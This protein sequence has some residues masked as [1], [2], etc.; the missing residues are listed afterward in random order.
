[1]RKLLFQGPNLVA[2]ALQV[3]HQQNR[4]EQESGAFRELGLQGA[5]DSKGLLALGLFGLRAVF[6][7]VWGPESLWE[8]CIRR[9]RLQD[10]TSSPGAVS[11]PAKTDVN[12]QHC[13]SNLNTA[14]KSLNVR[15][16]VA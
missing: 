14:P 3:E 13:E 9:L 2:A 7:G 6:G 4:P 5:F 15:L 16:R 11:R 10:S 8:G 1:M 12:M